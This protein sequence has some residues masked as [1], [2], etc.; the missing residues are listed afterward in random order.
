M[1]IDPHFVLL[2]LAGFGFAFLLAVLDMQSARS[3]LIATCLGVMLISSI[4]ERQGLSDAEAHTG[5]VMYAFL[6]LIGVLA[7][8]F[9][10]KMFVALGRIVR[11]SS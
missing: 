3:A 1:P 5:F 2:F 8:I 6:F 11:R 9:V 4:V 10:H 7:S